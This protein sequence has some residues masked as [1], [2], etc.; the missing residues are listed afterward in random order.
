MSFQQMQVSQY[1]PRR[2]A[3]VSYP[4]DGKST[5]AAQMRTPILPI[6][7]D[8]RF[9]EVAPLA[10]GDVYQLS[11]NPQDHHNSDAIARILESDMPGSATRT[12]VVDSLTAILQPLVIKAYRDN[13]AG[14]NKNRAAAYADKATAMR[15]LQHAVSKWGTDTL[16]IYHLSDGIDGAAQNVT[17]ET[18]PQTERN[19]LQSSL[20][21]ELRII[22]QGPRRGI[23]VIWARQGRDGLTL[24]DDSGQ[25]ANM[26]ER[27]EAAVY[28]GLT[29]QDQERIAQTAPAVFPNPSAALDWAIERG[30]FKVLQHAQNAYEKVKREGRP[31]DAAAMRDLWVKDIERRLAEA[32]PQAA[33]IPP[34]NR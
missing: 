26:P 15:Q 34:A 5:F 12:I 22:R 30:A 25:W 32:M 27:I 8:H 31:R 11:D 1:P 14:R 9:I 17:R 20:N 2:W 29:D 7:A 19:R 13:S 24:W 18:L 10:N 33:A 3:L 6:D 28:D 21:M 23:K 4:G 16:W